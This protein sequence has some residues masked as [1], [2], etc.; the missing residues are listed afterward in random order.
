MTAEEFASRLERA[1]KSGSGYVARCPAHQ[2]REPSLSV[3]TGDDGRILLHCHANCAPD[4][5]VQALGLTLAD[6][7]P[8]ETH[9]KRE[10]TAR[11]P[12]PDEHG[13]LLYEVVR[14]EAPGQG[15]T[16]R[17]R[18]P[19]GQG[20]WIWSL[21]N[22]RRVLYRLPELQAAIQAGHTIY[23]PEG[24]KDV[25]AL[26]QAG[27]TAT[28][29]PGGAGKWRPEYTT[30]L[31]G[32]QHVVVIADRDDTGLAHARAIHDALTE[33]GVPVEI[34]QA[35]RG[36][37]AY[38]HLAAGLTLDQLEPLAEKAPEHSWVP[39][40]LDTDDDDEQ[41][42]QRILGLFYPQLRH[43]VYGEPE[44]LKTW[45]ALCAVAEIVKAGGRALWIDHEM[46]AR[47]IRSRLRN[48]GCD[49]DARARVTYIR[50]SSA[51]DER[52]RPYLQQLLD[53]EQPSIVVV[54]AYTGALGLAMLDDNS[55][56]DVERWNQ[57]IGA[58]LWGPEKRCLVILDH[59]NKD[60]DTRGRWSSGSKRKLEGADVAY[61][62]EMVKRL[63]RQPGQGGK[64]KITAHKD[65]P[66]WLPSMRPGD[67][68]LHVQ[69]DG[70][71]QYAIVPVET[72]AGGEKRLTNLMEKV[73]RLLELAG[74]SGLSKAQVERE[75]E[76]RA[77]NV[78]SAIKTLSDE[79]YV[80]VADAPPGRPI[81]LTSARAY[82][83]QWDT[84]ATSSTSSDLVPTSSGTGFADTSSTSSPPRSGER[85][86][87]TRS[88][89]GPDDPD[90]VPGSEAWLGQAPI[91]EVRAW[92]NQQEPA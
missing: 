81:I 39:E 48:L 42:P 61:S 67:L 30:A 92:V 47:V 29:N 88:A 53:Q 73:S 41:E 33:A 40:P 1:K 77:V 89:R 21:G 20:G 86:D 6:L 60:K 71:I 65:R 36:K 68:E 70:A 24:E 64:A 10:I 5:I 26:E 54:D 90:L 87:G 52:S 7:F 17:Q 18:R 22:T 25:H 14:L 15:K 78:R 80:V 75:I 35:A 28:C 12:Y 8:P 13:T 62:M 45:L 76:S 43:L 31:L 37:D 59:V 4:A 16:F 91:D 82:R 56:I 55:N 34:R 83:E 27:A 49:K 74:P 58:L 19:D 9:G 51:L 44:S 72:T 63:G 50:P 84:H 79:G 32:A 3:S 2:D 46:S 23:I 66:A 69:A 38:D 11:Y 57:T 85:G